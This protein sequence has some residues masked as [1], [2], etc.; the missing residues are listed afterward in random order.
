[1]AS[2]ISIS[3]PLDVLLLCILELLAQLDDFAVFRSHRPGCQR[4]GSSVCSERR[5]RGYSPL[6]PACHER[7]STVLKSK[8]L[9]ES[10]EGVPRFNQDFPRSPQN[11]EAKTRS[12][13]GS[14][15]NAATEPAGSDDAATMRGEEGGDACAEGASCRDVATT[16]SI[17]RLDDGGAC[18]AEPAVS[19]SGEQL[20]S[21]SSGASA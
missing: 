4:W 8:P 11:L 12:L 14:I 17:V 13:P 3:A 21:I 5:L 7:S 19:N 1:M 15:P 18:A 20:A 6:L 16:P 9:P 2:S 10:G